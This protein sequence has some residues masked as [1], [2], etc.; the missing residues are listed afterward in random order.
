MKQIN[1][2][3]GHEAGDR[4]LAE[5]ARRL[6]GVARDTDYVIRWGGEEF[7]LVVC[8]SPADMAPRIAERVM[9]ALWREPFAVTGNSPLTLTGS[10]GFSLF[11]FGAAGASAARH[12]PRDW[13]S[14]FSFADRPSPTCP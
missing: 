2:V 1:D 11:P 3:H 14:V 13:Q 7:L 10:V 12:D 6:K 5:T 9:R 8:F 4:V